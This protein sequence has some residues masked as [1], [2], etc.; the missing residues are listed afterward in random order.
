MDNISKRQTN[1]MKNKIRRPDDGI[2]QLEREKIVLEVRGLNTS[3]GTT[4][5][6]HDIYCHFEQNAV[7]AIMGPSGCGKSTLVNSLNRIL[8][9]VP[10]A[11]IISGE[12]V[13]KGENIYA[14]NVNTS[15]IR[16]QI[17]MIFQ[18]P[19]VF[20]MSI[21]DNVLFGPE[22]HDI[23]DK[24]EKVDYAIHYL[25]R[26]GLFKELEGRLDDLATRLSG[27]QQQRLCLARALANQPK[28]LLMDEPC[29]AL[30]PAAMRRI[31]DLILE[32]SEE[33]TI[34]IVTHNLGQ[35]RRVSNKTLFLYDGRVIEASTTKQIFE[36]PKTKLTQD[37]I[38]GNIG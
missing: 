15:E 5:T 38:I 9:M 7:S 31:E 14:P 10:G 30:D 11:R 22:F 4:K 32:L 29:S 8:E 18:R 36:N 25:K 23:C 21:I 3:Y 1:V 6:L 2:L 20:P 27:G 33:Y 12:V 16:K 26:V 17:G 37:F 19:V 35:A 28:I 34:I 24:T 13:Y